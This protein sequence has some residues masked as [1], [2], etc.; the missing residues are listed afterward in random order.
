MSRTPVESVDDTPPAPWNAF[1]DEHREIFEA[2]FTHAAIGMALVGVDGRFLKVNRALCSILGF[3]DAE[4]LA[5]DFQSLTH[6]DDLPADL[7]LVAQLLAGEIDHYHLEKRY[8]RRDKQIVWTLL[9]VSLVRNAAD[10]PEFFVAQ[11]Q[12]ISDRKRADFELQRLNSQ[13]VDLANRDPLTQLLNRR[14]MLVQLELLV[15]AAR[16]KRA[17]LSC[18]LL[19]VDHFKQLNDTFGH[20][21]GDMVLC[22]VAEVLRESCRKSDIYA[23]YG[24]EEFL[25]VCPDTPPAG[26][27]LLA[28]RIRQKLQ[29]RAFSTGAES[30]I[31]AGSFGVAAWQPE[32][33]S[34][35]DLIAA[36]DQALYAAKRAGRD[37][38]I[39]AE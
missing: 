29:A 23:R 39:V 17:P 2:A 10:L 30:F 22:E 36:A 34:I 28:E 13:L 6:A 9:S 33:T 12:D 32:H 27:Y 25:V 16:E 5:T 7:D 4:L 31:V 37:R 21:V 38:T 8:L 15:A 35:D 18:V 11:V 20:R 1:L 19:D 14:G 3:T 24:G 26:A